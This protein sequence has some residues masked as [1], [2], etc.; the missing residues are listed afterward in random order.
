MTSRLDILRL[1]KFLTIEEAAELLTGETGWTDANRAATELIREAIERGDL[2]AEEVHFWNESSWDFDRSRAVIDQ[3]ATTITRENFE[4]W[5]RRKGFSGEMSP[6]THPTEG[7]ALMSSRTDPVNDLLER[8]LGWKVS[9]ILG[10][11][12]PWASGAREEIRRLGLTRSSAVERASAL[13]AWLENRADHYD[14]TDPASADQMREA[15]GKL[16]PSLTREA[17]AIPSE[18]SA[19]S[20]RRVVALCDMPKGP[21]RDRRISERYQ[22]LQNAGKQAPLKL[23]AEEAGVSE[24]AIKAARKRHHAKLT[25]TVRKTGLAAQ[26]MAA[27]SKGRR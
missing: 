3:H 27:N 4:T 8:V 10:T 5:R 26:V 9:E 24:S 25:D 1:R 21:E 14:K 7:N 22:E 6:P 18:H 17:K 2:A 16:L 11:S 12:A 13:A 20:A 19:H 23:V 15:R